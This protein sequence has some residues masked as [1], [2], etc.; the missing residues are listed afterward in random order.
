MTQKSREQ[1]GRGKSS[2]QSPKDPCSLARE[3]TFPR[4]LLLEGHFVQRLS[5][6]SREH[7]LPIHLSW[8][9][10]ASLHMHAGS[11]RKKRYQAENLHLKEGVFT[12][13]VSGLLAGESE[14]Q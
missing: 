6:F 11:H 7:S 10:M 12:G 3:P 5:A 4:P 2:R 9:A 8:Q 13:V 14:K 1:F